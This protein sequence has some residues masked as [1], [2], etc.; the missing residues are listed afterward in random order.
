MKAA[1]AL[2]TAVVLVGCTGMPAKPDSANAEQFAIV[3]GNIVGG[4]GHPVAGV[5]ITI[6]MRGVAEGE[7]TAVSEAEGTFTVHVPP[8]DMYSVIARKGCSSEFVRPMTLKAGEVRDL[9]VL[10]LATAPPA[11]W[12]R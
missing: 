8:G 7:P 11:G 4:D 9:G 1:L 10:N 3:K 12:G 5:K 6:V 2:L